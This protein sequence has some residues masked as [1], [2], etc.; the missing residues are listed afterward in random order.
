LLSVTKAVQ[1]CISQNLLLQ[2]AINLGI[3][4]YNK[5][6]EYIKP[7]IKET[8]GA[9]T[10]ISSIAMAIRRHIEKIEANQKKNSH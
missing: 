10:K 1:D 6:A 3:V 4:S 2:E 9:K 8:I 7:E 5:L